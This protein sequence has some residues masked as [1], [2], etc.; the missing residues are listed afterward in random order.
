PVS[1]GPGR[2]LSKTRESVWPGHDCGVPPAIPTRPCSNPNN[3]SPV[4]RRCWAIPA[5]PQTLWAGKIWAASGPAHG[6]TLSCGPKI[7]LTLT[8]MTWWNCRYNLPFV[9]AS[10]F[11]A[12]NHRHTLALWRSAMSTVQTDHATGTTLRRTLGLPSAILFGLA[13]MVPLTV[14]TTYGIVTTLTKGH[15]PSAYIITLTA[16][17]VT[18]LAYANMVK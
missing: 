18:A 1:V 11:T 12:A 7:Q 16:M 13:Y 15:L 4:P 6:P 8:P 14:F 3:A 10:S 5:G 2:C 9:T 17:L